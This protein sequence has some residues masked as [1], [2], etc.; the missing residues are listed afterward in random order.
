MIHKVGRKKNKWTP[1][2]DHVLQIAIAAGISKADIADQLGLTIA[3]IEA[4][5][6]KLKRMEKDKRK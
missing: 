2:M 6:Y 5:Y 1:A 4:R 3:A